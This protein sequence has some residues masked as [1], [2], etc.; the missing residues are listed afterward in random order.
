MIY[1]VDPEDIETAA[2]SSIFTFTFTFLELLAGTVRDSITVDSGLIDALKGDPKFIGNN[3]RITAAAFLADRAGNLSGEL[4][5]SP[6]PSPERDPNIHVLDL[7]PATISPVRPK[8]ATSE[9]PDSSRFTALIKSAGEGLS[10]VNLTDGTTSTNHK[11]DLNPFELSVDEGLT[12]IQVTFVTDGD[13]ISLSYSGENNAGDLDNAVIMDAVNLDPALIAGADTK[14][15]DGTEGPDGDGVPDAAVM[16]DLTN[17]IIEPAPGDP[18]AVLPLEP[19]TRKTNEQGGHNG[20]WTVTVVDSA[21]NVTHDTQTDIWFDGVAPDTMDAN[22]F[23]TEAGAPKDQDTDVPTINSATTAV[24]LRL[25]EAL[26]S[27]GVQYV[28]N[29]A[30]SPTTSIIRVSP[31]DVN[32]AITDSPITLTLSDSLITGEEYKLQV[33]Q[34]DL[35]GNVS[36]TAAQTLLYDNEFP[37]PKASEFKIAQDNKDVVAGQSMTI[38]V[39]AL[40]S[41]MTADTG[42]EVVAVIHS[43]EAFIRIEEV[44]S[45]KKAAH[46][47]YTFDGDGVTDNED[48][49]ATLD[50]DNWNLGVRDFDIVST[51]IIEDFIVIVE[52]K[53]GDDVNFDGRTADTLSVEA[54]DFRA[55]AVKVLEDGVETDGVS[56]EFDV[57]VH[58][59]DIHGNPSAKV[60]KAKDGMNPVE[61]DSLKLL[62]ANID[63][64]NV[65]AETFVEFSASAGD[66][67]VPQ[68]P[69]ALPGE[70][71]SFT[72]TAPDR[73]GKGLVITVRSVNAGTLGFTNDVNEKFKLATG[74]SRRIDGSSRLSCD[75]EL[76][77]GLSLNPH[78]DERGGKRVGGSRVA[79]FRVS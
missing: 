20:S 22:Y 4:A 15:A 76:V 11:L 47:T 38:T 64:A 26:D 50:T 62:A 25:S 6:N 74:S 7:T 18:K 39:T 60:M 66:V 32:L 13:E 8:T 72:V 41:V 67:D 57:W 21:G 42:S 37:N 56:G 51:G 79:E 9:L 53:T 14:L 59:T 27:L 46:I 5:N 55:F 40:D 48:G 24:V 63:P 69:Q 54:A 77:A 3:R 36:M 31:G 34:R 35:A 75:R 33:F 65:L 29:T 43:T 12:D 1:I 45:A 70:G 17:L 10:I 61:A 30:V 23:P 68:G 78:F 2:D 71:S 73:A 49:T 52:D 28:E 58:P 44:A 16:F 19:E